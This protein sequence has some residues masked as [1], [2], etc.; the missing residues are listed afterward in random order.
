MTYTSNQCMVLY[1]AIF[2]TQSESV[3]CEFTANDDF[4]EVDISSPE[5]IAV[6]RWLYN[7]LNIRKSVDVHHLV[8]IKTHRMSMKVRSFLLIILVQGIRPWAVHGSPGPDFVNFKPN[9]EFSAQEI[10]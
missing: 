9:R 1:V 6:I 8:I 10:R 4:T 2:L 5:A 7:D 3:N